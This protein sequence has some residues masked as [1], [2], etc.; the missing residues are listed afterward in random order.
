R[1]RH[2]R[3]DSAACV[4]R[5]SRLGVRVTQARADSAAC[6]ASRDGSRDAR[7]LTLKGGGGG[8]GPRPLRVTPAVTLR[9]TLH[10]TVRVTLAARLDP[11]VAA[12]L[13]VTVAARLDVAGSDGCCGT[14]AFLGWCYARHQR[15]VRR[16]RRR[17]HHHP[18]SPARLEC[19]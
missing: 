13:D 15:P 12:P 1:V 9:V 4:E 10:V 18:Q 7:S 14:R 6:D 3:A 8:G 19:H 17:G 2:V 11:T 16:A 5:P